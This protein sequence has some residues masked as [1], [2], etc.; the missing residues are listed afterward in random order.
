MPRAKSSYHELVG[1]ESF[2]HK[3]KPR[4]RQCDS[5]AKGQ[6]IGVRLLGGDAVVNAIAKAGIDLGENR[7]D[8]KAKGKR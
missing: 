7:R 3:K 2:P 8:P 5:Q 1:V 6:E 4:L